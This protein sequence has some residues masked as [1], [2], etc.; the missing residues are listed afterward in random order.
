[1]EIFTELY[2]TNTHMFTWDVIYRIT[3]TETEE[4]QSKEIKYLITLNTIQCFGNAG[5]KTAATLSSG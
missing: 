2:L 3:H 1:V 5:V 4:A